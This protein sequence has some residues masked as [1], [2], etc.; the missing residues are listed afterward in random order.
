MGDKSPK[1]KDKARKQEAAHK[2]KV[3]A[4]HDTK[5]SPPAPAPR[6]SPGRK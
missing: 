6:S 3:Q 5:Q 2:G 4:A 1:S